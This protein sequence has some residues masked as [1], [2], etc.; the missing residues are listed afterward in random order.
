MNKIVIL[1]SDIGRTAAEDEL[2]CLIQAEAISAALR[3]LDY[4]PI[5]IPFSLDLNKTIKKLRSSKPQAV[6]NIVETLQFSYSVLTKLIFF[7]FYINDFTSAKVNQ[8]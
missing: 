7:T 4:H 2:D 8:Y 3:K 1:H 5:L 6:F